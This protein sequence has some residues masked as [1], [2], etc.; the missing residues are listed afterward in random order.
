MPINFHAAANSHTYSGR[1]ADTSWRTA[2]LELVDPV[3]A[4]VADI[5]CGG[6][7][8]TRAWLELGA[9][10]VTGVDFSAQILGAAR[11]ALDLPG[12]R[13]V[14]GEAAATGLPDSS[15]DVVFQ[16]ALVHHVDDLHAVVMEAARVLRPGGALIIQDRTTDDAFVPGSPT[17][18]RG[19]LF[20]I[21]PQLRAVEAQRRP[22]SYKLV[23][24][25]EEAGFREPVTRTLWETRREY[26]RREDYLAEIAARTGR[27]LLHELSDGEL[28]KVVN[29][30]RER[31]PAGAVSERDRWTLWSGVAP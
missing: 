18:P 26:A 28:I 4:D 19:W 24:A 15:V 23:R 8:Y 30:L 25:M 9:S 17:H 20:D 12:A 21:A 10:T 6:G 27:S 5:G 29:Q 14:L 3:D 31:L 13:F 2:M 16:R 1:R 11:E 22:E 7:T